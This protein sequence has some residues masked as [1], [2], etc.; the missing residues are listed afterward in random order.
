MTA[1]GRR[2]CLLLLATSLLAGCNLGPRYQRPALEVPAQFRSPAAAGAQ[3]WPEPGWWRGFGAPELDGLIAAAQAGN[4]NLAAAVAR[5]READAQVRIA[6]AALL[7]GITAQAEPSLTQSGGTGRRSLTT[8]TYSL[9]PLQV[10]YE[11]DFWGRNRASAESA[12]A[13]ALASRFDQQTVALSVVVSVAS[14]YF[15]ALAARDRLAVARSNLAD[16]EQSL[17]VIRG[18]LAAGTATALDEAQE[19]A[20]VAAIRANIP[21]LQSLQDQN[22]IGLGILVGRPPEAIEVTAATLTSLTA[23]EVAPGLPSALLARRPDVA[24]AEANLLA[25]NGNVR[26][27]RAAFFPQIALTGALGWSSGAL[28]TLFGPAGFGASLAATATQTIFDNGS[29]AGQ[30]ALARGRYDELVADYRQAVLQAFTDVEN[31]LTEYRYDTEQ[32]ALEAQ[33]VTA[34]RRAADIA[35]AQLAAGTVD[36]TTLLTAQTTLYTE[37]DA[38]AQIRLARFTALLNLYQALGGGWTQPASGPG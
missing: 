1:W 9:T 31:A 15:A 26:A 12:Q 38:L 14:T 37:L 23:P 5:V 6:G 13:G 32:E 33:A 34:A 18:R 27:A 16:G 30:L 24:Y 17:A 11:A 10:S 19:L 3:V 21:A 25:Q 4:Q 2:P 29:L 28:A 36:V 20:Q 7:P 22:V 35:R 8:H